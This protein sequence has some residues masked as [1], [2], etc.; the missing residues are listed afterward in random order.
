MNNNKGNLPP[1]SRGTY[2]R[3]PSAAPG[4]PVKKRRSKAARVLRLF[5]AVLLIAVVAVMIYGGSLLWKFFHGSFGVDQPVASGQL[6]SQK[7]LTLLLL[8]TDN[9]PKHK[10]NLTD[11]IMVVSMN[12]DTQKATVVSLPRDTYVQLSGYKK[13]KINEFYARFKGKEK[14]SGILAKDEMKTMMGK[15]LDIKVDYTAVLDFQGFRDIVDELGGVSVNISENMCYTDSVD[16]TDINL[17]QGPAKLDG[18]DA[19]DYVRYR[20]S[21]CSPQTKA[22]NDFERNERQSE[23]LNALIGKMQSLGGVLKIGSVMDSID[24]NL[25]TDIENDQIK[26]FIKTYWKIPKENVEFKPVTGTW[27]SPYV[28][29]NEEELDAAKKALQTTLG[30]SN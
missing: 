21:N 16:G 17:K 26:S 20:K 5:L 1:R 25:T 15:Y 13:T 2:N 14:T 11:V 27:R 8:G 23:V 7:P 18:D 3:L 6:A 10:S 24:E 30:T 28:Y 22:S 29:I 12:P 19:L 9:R 4:K